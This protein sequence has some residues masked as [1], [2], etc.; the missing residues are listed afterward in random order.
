M[1]V[2]RITEIIRLGR[3]LCKKSLRLEAV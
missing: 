3:I 2:A 1:S